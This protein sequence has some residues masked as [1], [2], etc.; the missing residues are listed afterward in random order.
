MPTIQV[1]ALEA[2]G[3]VAGSYIAGQAL[4]L[5]Y[6]CCKVLVLNPRGYD[7]MDEQ[8][9]LHF[10][11]ATL[12]LGP[13]IGVVGTGRILNQKGSCTGAL[14]GSIIGTGAAAYIEMY[15]SGPESLFPF[16]FLSLTCAH[17]SPIIGYNYKTLASDFFRTPKE[18]YDTL[19]NIGW[20]KIGLFSC[21]VLLGLA[22]VYLM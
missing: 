8:L 18:L 6:Y 4:A 22:G 14:I 1:Y 16:P 7:V 13:P 20:S 11:Y 17:L 10:Y 15:R 5:G 9:T 19:S 3:S 21:I 2:M 12:L